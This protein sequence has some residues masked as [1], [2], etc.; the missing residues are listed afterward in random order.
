MFRTAVVPK[1][2]QSRSGSAIRTLL[3]L[4]QLCQRVEFHDLA[5]ER[6]TVDYD[7]LP[8]PKASSMWAKPSRSII[9]PMRSLG[10]QFAR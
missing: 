7:S 3:G 1:S 6:V 4:G 2:R 5:A 8:S 9:L 10:L